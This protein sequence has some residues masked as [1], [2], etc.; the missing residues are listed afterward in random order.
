MIFGELLTSTN[1]NKNKKKITGGK[2]GYG[3]KLTNIFSTEFIVETI[4]HKRK[5][6]FIQKYEN[7]M[8][9]KNKPII[10]DYKLKP[11]T[12]I[13]FKPDLKRFGINNLGDGILKLIKKE[14]MI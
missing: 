14:L 11:Y 13:T 12:I 5:K 8:K 10:T 1:Y 9:I 7:N 3:A 6:K 2:N 4:D